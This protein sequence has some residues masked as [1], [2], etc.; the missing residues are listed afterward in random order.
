MPELNKRMN[1][2]YVLMDSYT[3]PNGTCY[4]FLERGKLKCMIELDSTGHGWLHTSST[5]RRI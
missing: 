4:Y 1:A 5:D 3:M 2:G